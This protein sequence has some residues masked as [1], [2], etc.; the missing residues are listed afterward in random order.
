MLSARPSLRRFGQVTL[1]F[2]W[3]AGFAVAPAAVAGGT[4]VSDNPYKAIFLRNLFGLR[5]VEIRTAPPPPAPSSTIMLTGI[6]TILGA[7]R[8]FL[9]I[10]PPAKPPQPAK[11]I[12]CILEEGQREGAV[13]VVQIDPKNGS[14]KVSEN[15]TLTTLTFEKNGRKTLPTPP[16]PATALH[17]VHAF[18]NPLL[19][20]SR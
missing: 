9:E 7:R 2:L 6:T 17:N 13:E 16:T 3:L 1:A 11:Q 8:A 20:P 5:P 18:R 15:G 12:S 10:T 4:N 14:V 19:R